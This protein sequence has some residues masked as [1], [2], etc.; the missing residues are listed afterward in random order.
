MTRQRNL[1][2]ILINFAPKSKE[3]YEILLSKER[4]SSYDNDIEAHFDNIKTIAFITPKL[5]TLEICLRNMCDNLL[6]EAYGEDWLVD[7]SDEKVQNELLKI[8]KKAGVDNPDELTRHQYIS[9]LTLGIFIRIIK[10]QGLENHIFNADNIDFKRYSGRNRN[11]GYINRR[12]TNLSNISKIDAALNL[13]LTIRN[14][15]FHWENLMKTKDSLPRITTYVYGSVIGIAPQKIHTFLDD[16]LSN[17]GEELIK[18]C[19]LELK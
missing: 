2:I 9:R 1:S 8:R 4:L 19:E 14:R 3:S 7:M 17:F 11:F 16:L 6:Y 15:S 10:E 13:L 12:K 18:N 5:A